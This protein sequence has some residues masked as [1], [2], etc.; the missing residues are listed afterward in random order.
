MMD[1]LTKKKLKESSEGKGKEEQEEKDKVIRKL[2]NGKAM[3]RE[4][5]G[6]K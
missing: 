4:E 6:A 5:E 3:R 2:K 1:F